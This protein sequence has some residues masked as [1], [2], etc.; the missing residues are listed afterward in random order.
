MRFGIATIGL[1]AA[2]CAAAIAVAQPPAPDTGSDIVVEGRRIGQ[3]EI[4]DFISALSDVRAD[5]HVARFEFDACPFAAGLSAEHNALVSARMRAVG[6]AA[7]VSIADPPCRPNA[8]IIATR[9]SRATIAD[10]RRHF[11][12]LFLGLSVRQVDRLALHESP[13]SWHIA[14]YVDQDGRPLTPDRE[15]GAIPVG[16]ASGASRLTPLVRPYLAGAVL[17]VDSRTIEGTT[18]RQLADYAAMRLFAK[19]DPSK[20]GGV[21]APTILRLLEA[22]PGRPMPVTLTHFDLGY[23]R[24][25]YATPPN[26]FANSQRFLMRRQMLRDLQGRE[27]GD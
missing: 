14:Q 1:S 27:V 11:P 3:S 20:L 25:L 17:V 5:D 4:G 15:T 12:Q 21:S 6:R 8:I 13:I 19:T 2:L 10:L 16:S 22:P 7:G 26:R 9:D 24:A 18:P 23:L